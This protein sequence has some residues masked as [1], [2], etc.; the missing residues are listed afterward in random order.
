[1]EGIAFLLC[2]ELTEAER[3]QVIVMK[4]PPQGR[5]TT[6]RPKLAPMNIKKGHS[7]QKG[8]RKP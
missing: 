7:G 2:H 8:W 6:P 5:E 3:D 4:I 1:M